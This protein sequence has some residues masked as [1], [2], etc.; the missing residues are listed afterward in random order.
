MTEQMPMQEMQEFVEDR[1]GRLVKKLNVPERLH[2][3]LRQ[4]LWVIAIEVSNRYY[5]PQNSFAK[6]RINTVVEREATKYLQRELD[7]RDIMEFIPAD[8]SVDKSTKSYQLQVEKAAAQKYIQE[9]IGLSFSSLT[10]RE[11]SILQH[12]MSD[13]IFIDERG[14]LTKLKGILNIEHRERM[15][16]IFKKLLRKMRHPSRSRRLRN[17]I[18]LLEEIEDKTHEVW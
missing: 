10:E 4:E 15:R 1:F 17:L 9:L 18:E 2:D 3:D 8:E 5:D 12:I 13:D 14:Y 16:Q 7:Y 11:Q 6:W